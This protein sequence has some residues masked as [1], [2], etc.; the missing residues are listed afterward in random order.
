MNKATYMPEIWGLVSYRL[1]IVVAS[2]HLS[3]PALNQWVFRG[4][5]GSC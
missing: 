2:V 5:M 1:D 4:S 3:L